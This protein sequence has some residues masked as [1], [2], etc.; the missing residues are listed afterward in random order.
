MQSFAASQLQRNSAEIQKAALM[1]PVFLTYH[2]KPRYVMMSLEEFVRI[3]GEEIA[4]HLVA[5]PPAVAVRVHELAK[6]SG[7]IESGPDASAADKLVLTTVNAPYKRSIDAATLR[8]SIAKCDLDRWLV[9][10]TTFF[11]DVAPE[12]VFQFAER[13]DISRSML[14]KAY[15][16]MKRKSGERN[17]DLEADLVRM[18]SSSRANGRWPRSS[19]RKRKR[20][21]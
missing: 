5:Y 17:P 20:G 18:A 1:G 6:A 7:P 8:D 12:L 13:H 15:R 2:D 19:S 3:Q 14:A 9:H 4:A 11:T 10:V 16:A 21:S